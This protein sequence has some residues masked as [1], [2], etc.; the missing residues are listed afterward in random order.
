MCIVS[1]P[2]KLPS[3]LDVMKKLFGV[4]MI[5]SKRLGTWWTDILVHAVLAGIQTK[6]RSAFVNLL[7]QIQ[8]STRK[9]FSSI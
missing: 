8:R 9:N 1:N 3:C 7:K 6:L 5:S 2:H 4:G